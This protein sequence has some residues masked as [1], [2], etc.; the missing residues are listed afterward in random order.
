MNSNIEIIKAR[1]TVL[2]SDASFV[3][4][5]FL[6][7]NPHFTLWSGSS[8]P[9]LHHYGMGGLVKHTCEVM[10]LCYQC[11]ETLKLHDVDDDEIFFA[12]LFHDVGKL[13][14]YIPVDA[15]YKEW[16]STDHKRLIH[17]ISRSALI[18]SDTISNF[19]MMT[20]RYHDAVLHAILAHHGQREW[21]SPVSPR[22]KLAWLLHLCD[23]ISARMNDADKI[24]QLKADSK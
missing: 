16:E 10:E 21:G 7:N 6:D 19:D 4:K 17:H 3:L 18:W 13:Y 11:K 2:G 20:I 1:A 14:D 9:Y 5:H 8:K 12:S 24:D 22:T 15:D 23:N